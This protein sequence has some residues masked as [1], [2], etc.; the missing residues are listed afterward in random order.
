METFLDAQWSGHH[1]FTA[2]RLDLIPSQGTK[3]S[4]ALLW[5]LYIYIYIYIYIHTHTYTYISMYQDGLMDG[6]DTK[7]CEKQIA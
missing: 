7:I 4:Q 2:E 6:P 3:I 1:S 5:P